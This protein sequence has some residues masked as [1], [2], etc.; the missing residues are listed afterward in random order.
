MS[1]IVFNSTHQALAAE[2]VLEDEG[3]AIEI[4]PLPADLAADCGLAIEFNVKSEKEVKK[5]LLEH[6]IEYKGIHV[7]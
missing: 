7:A 5:V 1:I 4:V 2:N 6:R 3:L